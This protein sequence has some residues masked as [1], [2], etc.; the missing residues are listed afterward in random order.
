M[1]CDVSGVER[2]PQLLP[3]GTVWGI[4]RSPKNHAPKFMMISRKLNSGLGRYKKYLAGVLPPFANISCRSVGLQVRAPLD[5]R[6]RCREGEG[7]DR[8]V[9]EHRAGRR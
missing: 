3:W 6:L 8:D 2:I 1:I 7:G 4:F 9:A 5:L